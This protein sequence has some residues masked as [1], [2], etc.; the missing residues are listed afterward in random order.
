MRLCTRKDFEAVN[1]AKIW[2][3][4]DKNGIAEGYMICDSQYENDENFYFK[5]NM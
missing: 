2:D 5:A 1:G 4:Y 3:D